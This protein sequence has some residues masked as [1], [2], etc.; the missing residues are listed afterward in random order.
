MKYNMKT[1]VVLIIGTFMVYCAAAQDAAT[2]TEAA[3]GPVITFEETS[4]DFGDIYQGDKVEYN[5]KFKNTGNEPLI[6]SNVQVTCGC[7]A[8][9]YPK[10]PVLPGANDEIRVTF[11]S[12]HKMG[13]QNKVVTIVSNAVSPNNKVTI[14]TNVLHKKTEGGK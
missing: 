1:L 12:A 13:K 6:I 14:V 11:N 7:T 3:S 9:Y 2:A 10:D 8:S 5:F 4:H